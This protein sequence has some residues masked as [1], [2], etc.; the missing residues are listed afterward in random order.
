LSLRIR[1]KNIGF[2]LLPILR[3]LR[4]KAVKGLSPAHCFS[5]SSSI[6]VEEDVSYCS[7]GRL[8]RV[9]KTRT[10]SVILLDFGKV[11]FNEKVKCCPGC[12]KTF[13][14][15]KLRE[16]VP[17]YSNFG[18]DIVE[19]IGR[20]L[21]SDNLTEKEVLQ[22][23]KERNVM[24]SPSE[25]AFLGKKFV[26]YLAQAHKNKESEIKGLVQRN[27]GY[28]VHLDGTCDGSS[29]HL[30]CALE[31]LLKLVLLS[32]KIPSESIDAIVS[33]LEELKVC[34]GTPL[35]IVCD[36]SAA[37]LGAI[38][39]I[40]PG[41]PIFICHFHFLRDL[42]KDLLKNDYELLLSEMRDF[43]VKSTLSRLTRDLR[44]LVGRYSSLSQHLEPSVKDIFSQKLPEEV[45][46]HLLVEWIQDYPKDLAGYG[47]PFDRSHLAQAERMREAYEHLKK[48]PLKPENRLIRVKA[49]LEEVL[50][51]GF[52]EC[53]ER[54]KKKVDHFDALRAIMRIAPVD[55]KNGLNDDG[56][57]DE[58]DLPIMKKRL[59]D[60]VSMEEIRGAA[61]KDSG[62]KKMLVQIARYDDFLFSKG[63][64]VMGMN[65]EK[66]HIQP[67]RTNNV[68][69]RF[70]R[71][72]K[73]GVRKRTG[74]KSMGQ[75][76][77]TMVAE[78]PYV[79][80][81]GNLEYLKVILNGKETLAE[82]FAEIDS[83]K[84]RKAMKKHYEDQDQL[85]PY[86]KKILEFNNL[87]QS[88]TESY[89]S[90]VS[91]EGEGMTG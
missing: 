35:G 53:I 77:K 29:P 72:T 2:Q 69:E 59:K 76:L 42:G 41:V 39:R 47:Y 88:I 1:K 31:E 17:E 61:I 20:K 87:L 60:F 67:E 65:G 32:R 51:E 16:L 86:V 79:K 6:P 90:Y 64:E 40:F 66:K 68:M 83:G 54:V 55:G 22:A 21:F 3:D 81:L 84:V 24:I 46:A 73:R 85:R 89:L 44:G 71:E 8:L 19:F 33:I 13:C 38:E 27:G 14:S 45:L 26:L 49:F 12:H 70:F 18:Y 34:Y 23:L 5:N 57:D 58:V 28:I 30:F 78:T 11:T 7:C 9:Q 52:Q 36:M 91:L 25:I 82:C 50:T 62:Y 74:C 10:R 56:D 37:I 63:I 15:Q 48:L 80:N 4:A 75:A 43:G